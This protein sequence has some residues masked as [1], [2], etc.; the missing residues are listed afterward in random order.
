VEHTGELELEIEAA[1]GEEV[2]ADALAALRE[3]LADGLDG[4]PGHAT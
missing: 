1:T 3:L 2:F 4:R